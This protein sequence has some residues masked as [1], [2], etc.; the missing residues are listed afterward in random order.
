MK[1]NKIKCTA[2][3]GALLTLCLFTGCS[4]GL[5]SANYWKGNEK[6]TKWAENKFHSRNS[7]K[8]EIV[9]TDDDDAPVQAFLKNGREKFR[10]GIVI[11]GDYWEFFDNMKGLVEGIFQ[12]CQNQL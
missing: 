11:S 4:F 10:I 1:M 7:N 9:Q 3:F 12:T 8:T 2:I 6:E 5:S